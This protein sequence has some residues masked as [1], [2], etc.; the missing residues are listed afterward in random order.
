MKQQQK[1]VLLWIFL[2]LMMALVAKVATEKPQNVK[3][4]KYPDFIQAVQKGHVEGVT[5]RG[6]N[7][8][9]GKFK[10]GY[11]GG[12][13]FRLTGSTGDETFKI[14]EKNSIYPEYEEDE[15]PGLFQSLLVN[16]GPMIILLIIFFFF[17]R[18]IQAGGGKAMSFGKSKARMLSA[19]DKKVTF[20]DVSGVEEAK[21]ELAEV[22]DFL[23]DPKK[24]TNLGGKI[25]KGVILV[26]PPGTG[27]TL[28][29]RAVAGEANV[30]F[31]SISGSDFV[32]MFVGV[33]A[34]RVRD[35]FEQGKKNAPC[36][37]FIDEID[38]VG[39][40]RGHGMGGGHDE[41]EQTLNQLLVEMDGFESN[42]GVILIAAT[43]RIDVLDPAL[44]RPGRF[45]RRVTVGPPDVRGRLGILKVHTRKTPLDQDVDLEVIA[46][47]TP[48]FTGADLANLVNE[49]ALMAARYNK[50]SLSTND[51]ELAKDK[52]LMGP[53]R[54]SMVIS[55]HE[56]KVTAYHE[57]GHTLVGMELPK[58]DPIHK[59]SIMP[60]GGALGVTQ[61]LPSEDA[62]NLTKEKGENLIAF[63]MGGRV[64]EEI[65]F[66]EISNGA[67]NDIEKATQLAHHMVCSWGM[68]D[69]L[70]PRNYANA[71]A[72]PFGGPGMKEVGYSDDTAK[73]IDSEIHRIIDENYKEATRIL[74]E[75]RDALNRIAE[76][77]IV[78]ET[79]DFK[80]VQDL[81][82]GKD[83]GVPL[84]DKVEAKESSEKKEEL[85]KNSEN[86]EENAETKKDE[87]S[88]A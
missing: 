66:G 74:T 43:N 14:L 50:K 68:S 24:Y 19:N 47:G 64:A 88:L 85:V 69:K 49:A 42:E 13:S 36:I 22:V 27:K 82:E 70:G 80:Q 18:Q 10:E 31:F 71:G 40:H 57:A 37:I 53:E 6:D 2:V 81:V 73:E 11:E 23:R 15:K 63:M 1:T 78:W 28:L 44:L 41:R 33:G 62:L 39:R 60:R 59:V 29:A 46:K 45:D 20:T 17:M 12:K 30:P 77:L 87:P 65:V 26:G 16:W 5:F 54:K 48:G 84:I 38:A 52:V 55:D 21:E 56:K 75:K 4:I 25:P 8:I 79:L 3:A 83:I 67:S 51:F 34:S 58:T 86:K 32:E 7:K 61:T 35:L 76:A 9:E 72:S